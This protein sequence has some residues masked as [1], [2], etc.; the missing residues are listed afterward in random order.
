MSESLRIIRLQ[1]NNFKR[2]KAIDITPTSNVVRISGPNASGKSS[3]LDAIWCA[4]GGKAG[5]PTKPIREGAEQATIEIDLGKYI[6]FRVFTKDDKQPPI[7]LRPKAG[8]VGGMAGKPIKSPQDLLDEMLGD[9]T[10]DPL[11]FARMKP[12]DQYEELRRI[13]KLGPELD[14]FDRLNA[15][16]YDQRTRINRLQKQ[17]A[18]EAK[19]IDVPDGL[20]DERANV[21][22]IADA[23]ERAGKHNAEIEKRRIA[24][25]NASTRISDLNARAER[26]GRELPGKLAAIEKRRAE[27][28]AELMRQIEIANASAEKEKLDM[29]G[30]DDRDAALLIREAAE[31]SDKLNAAPP[32]PEPQDVLIYKEQIANA[33]SINSGI[34]ARDKHR[35]R[36]GEAD[37][38]AKQAKEL[39]EAMEERTKKKQDMIAA[40]K[41][42]I[43]GVSLDGGGVTYNGIPFEQSSTAEQLRVSVAIAMAANPTLRILRIKEGSLLDKHSLAILEEMCGRN[44]FQAWIECVSDDKGAIGL[45]LE[46]GKIVADNQ[47]DQRERRLSNAT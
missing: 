40:A 22:E 12:K 41:M 7:L 23:M 24:R 5:V 29:Q 6:L 38:Y 17:A 27:R 4:I 13:V 15:L 33:Q 46:D 25:A 16:D 31:L 18:A 9:L 34:D 39:T 47:E 45:V 19:L 43:P 30:T 32:L 42:P 14:E 3:V 26:I 20:P 21:A 44:N 8:G 2:L 35:Q 10:F 28:V 37:L 1:A 11:A 36:Q